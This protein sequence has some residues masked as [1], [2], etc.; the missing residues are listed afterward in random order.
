MPRLVPLPEPFGSE[1]F[2]TRFAIDSGLS[3]ERLRRRDL[4][5]PYWGVRVPSATNLTL[6]L[7]CRAYA[8]RI[9][10]DA[11]FSHLTAARLLGFPLPARFD[12]DQRLHIATPPPL[13]SLRGHGVRGHKLALGPSEVVRVRDIPLTSA[14]R[15]WVDLAKGVSTEELI[16]LGDF[17]LWRRHP[18]STRDQLAEA[19]DRARGR[20]GVINASRALPHLTDRADSPPESQFRYRFAEAGLPLALPNVELFTNTGEFLAM[21]DLVFEQYHEVFDYEGDHHRTEERQWQKDIARVRKLEEN[22]WHSTRGSKADLRDSS[23]LIAQMTRLFE[24]KGWRR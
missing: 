22:G 7:L 21:P 14:A 24:S 19:V 9:P 8:T 18:L 16:V 10:P 15:T 1:P 11:S 4:D 3:R 13:R 5:R 12:S 17:L 20:R 6:D 23:D 2:S